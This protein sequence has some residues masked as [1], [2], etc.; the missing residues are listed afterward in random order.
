MQATIA[1]IGMSVGK[2]Y[3]KGDENLRII[4]RFN[5]EQAREMHDSGVI[6]I[7]SHSY[8]M[9]DNP[10]LETGPYREGV[11]QM[12]GESLEEYKQA[13]RADFERSRSLIEQY[14]GSPMHVFVYPYG[15]YSML[16]EELLQEAGVKVTV[17]THGGINTIVRGDPQ[18]LFLL[19]RIGVPGDKDIESI[20]MA[21]N[22]IGENET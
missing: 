12:E 2:D 4:P 19:R 3:Y 10:Q 5:W 1:V 13:F 22:V 6:Q 14:V 20:L 21:D 11:L 7:V 18:S 16:T 8:A 15:K 17:S 9:H